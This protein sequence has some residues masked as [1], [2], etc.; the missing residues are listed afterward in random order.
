MTLAQKVGLLGLSNASGYENVTTAV[1]SLC[2]PQFVLNDG[3]AGI[4]AGP[5]G[6]HTQL[7]APIGVA[8]SWD[9]TLAKQY[10]AVMGAEASAKGIDVIQ[11]PDVNIARVP[12]SGR[13]FETFGED[14]YLTSQ[15]GLATAQGI[16]SQGVGSMPKHFAVY[17]QE[18]YRNTTAD[19]AIVSQRTLHEIYLPAW[20]T[21]VTKGN[22]SSIMCAYSEVN[23]TFS[24][25]NPSLLTQILD[26]RWGFQGFIRSDLSASHST[27]D[28]LQAGTD[29]LKPAVPQQ[30]EQ[31]LYSGQ[32]SG[33]QLDD[34]VRRVLGQMFQLG[35]F[36][37]SST[38]TANTNASTS[39]HVTF[40]QTAAEDS[41]VL[42]KD[43]GGVLP[44]AGVH[45]IAVIGA[46]AGPDA[47]TATPPPSADHVSA[48]SIVT[49]YEGIQARAGTGVSVTYAQGVANLEGQGSTSSDQVDALRQAAARQAAASQVA[50][51]FVADPESEG[52]DLQT[53]SLPDN[54]DQLIEAVAAA[55]PNTVVVLNT[56]TPVTM[57]WLSQVRGV[58]EAWYPGQQDGAAV[59]AVLFGDVDPGGKLPITFPT[60]LSETPVATPAQFPGVGG[61]VQYS[62]GLDVGYRWYAANKVTPLFPFG[63]GLSYTTFSFRHLTVSPTTTTSVGTVQVTATV[64]NT[65]DRAGSE[66]AQLYLDDPASAGE[67]PLQLKGFQ[68]VTLNA[69][70]SSQVHFTLSPHDLS[71]W[72]STA[73]TWVVTDGTYR[74][75]VGDSSAN[76]PLDADLQV[77]ATTW[78]RA[79]H[80][81]APAQVESGTPFTV[82]E[83]LTAGGDLSLQ[84]VK[85]QLTSPAGWSVRAEGRTRLGAVGPSQA[86]TVSW[87]VTAPASAQA[88]EDLLTA[89]AILQTA[90]GTDTLTA[91]SQITVR[92]LVTAAIEPAEVFMPGPTGHLTLRYTDTSG[93]RLV[94]H[95]VATPAQGLRLSARP[96]SGA[97]TLRPGGSGSQQISLTGSTGS[98]VLPV[99]LQV[100]VGSNTLTSPAVYANISDPLASLSAAFDNVG[101]TAASDPR[102]GNYSGTGVTFSAAALAQ[103]GLTPGASVTR[104]GITFTWP[105]VPAGQRDNV[106]ADGQTIALSGQGSVLG[107]L[108]ATANGNA[109]G[110]GTITYTDGTTQPFTLT[111]TDWYTSA[112]APQDQIV[113]ISRFRNSPS[114]GDTHLAAVFS[115]AVPLRSGKT[116]AYVTLPKIGS[117]VAAGHTAMHI[118]A[119]AIGS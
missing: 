105:N 45:S 91:R 71:Y 101:I 41:M 15:L 95:W 43:T 114:G 85:F 3:P 13:N 54:Q 39:A 74:I 109:T 97:S 110:T 78:T 50:V 30:I 80:L 34:A 70:Q 118:F 72:D 6:S 75:M 25:E 40:A 113:A 96:A 49:P 52:T 23:G 64:T 20:W 67:P 31:A 111:L 73:Q 4:I 28:S 44:L 55:N 89:T 51:V 83:A 26:T 58:L 62:E 48:A 36:N 2:I 108:G 77:H 92:P 22:V 35:V 103:V 112:P 27:L 21:L 88:T 37:R 33:T 98:A 32:I 79:V 10:G 66:V 100:R 102:A 106:V 12:L 84:G 61:E 86:E 82:T 63:F 14:P 57:P 5:A 104:D 56:A 59:A 7:P 69:G 90:G 65:G 24:C 8:A 115:T 9:P 38:G 19:N 60:S 119:M 18:T 81:A 46:D 29:Q 11:A 116:V 94:L 117:T 16:E 87:Q 42:L 76:L 47:L 107:F 53:L 99:T 93:Y 1:P 17:N 68:K